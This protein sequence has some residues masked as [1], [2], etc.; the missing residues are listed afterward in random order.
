M[1]G[2]ADQPDFEQVWGPSKTKSAEPGQLF[3]F[4]HQRMSWKGERGMGTQ[5]V[6]VDEGDGDA[7]D[8]GRDVEREGVDPLVLDF[9]LELDQVRRAVISEKRFR[10]LVWNGRGR[11]G[12]DAFEPGMRERG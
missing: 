12:T 2:V 4:G 7:V 5:L 3:E 10:W 6:R 9:E 8:D 11:L 1:R